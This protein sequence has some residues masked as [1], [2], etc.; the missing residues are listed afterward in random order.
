MPGST[1]AALHFAYVVN[2]DDNTLSVLTVNTASGQLRHRGY[3]ATDA[4]PCD[5]AVTPSGNYLYVANRGA[6]S[7]SGYSVDQIRAP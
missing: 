6:N 2:Q 1:D 4:A 7:I 3:V 5:V